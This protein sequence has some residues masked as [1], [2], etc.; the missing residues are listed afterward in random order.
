MPDRAE[1]VISSFP[2]CPDCSS[3][4]HVPTFRPIV[5]AEDTRVLSEF[6]ALSERPSVRY[7][8]VRHSVAE[9]AVLTAAGLIDGELLD[10]D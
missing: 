8:H 1:F 4:A 7:R 9:L 5:D 2:R 6:V 10:G 3:E